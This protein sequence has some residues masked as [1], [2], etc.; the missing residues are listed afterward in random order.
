MGMHPPREISSGMLLRGG[1]KKEKKKV[2]IE[3]MA[4]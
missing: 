3:F 4:L 2:E 1:E